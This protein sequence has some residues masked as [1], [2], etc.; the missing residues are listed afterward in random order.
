[1]K[2]SKKIINEST[3][4]ELLYSDL[5]MLKNLNKVWLKKWHKRSLYLYEKKFQIYLQNHILR[6]AEYFLFNHDLVMQPDINH[7]KKC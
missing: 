4:I 7:I 2:E 3:M 5:I 1:M 6:L